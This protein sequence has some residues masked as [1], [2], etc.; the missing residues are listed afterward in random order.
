MGILKAE[1]FEVETVSN[2]VAA[3]K[4]LA[5]LRPV[6]VLADVSMPGRD[7]YEVCDFVKKSPDLSRVPVFLVAS[8]MEPYDSAKGASVKADGIIKKPFESRE[9]ISLVVKFAEQFEAATITTP[10]VPLSYLAKTESV[11]MPA[12]LIESPDSALTVIQHAAPEFSELAGGVAFAEPIGEETHPFAFEPQSV[13]SGV[14]PQSHAADFSESAFEVTSV[15]NHEYPLVADTPIQPS[16]TASGTHEE[17]EVPSFMEHLTGAP[18]EPVFINEHA[19]DAAM[20]SET[21]AAA[22][23]AIFH[24]PLDIGMPE[25][26]DKTETSSPG[27]GSADLAALEPQF[28]TEDPPISAEGGH[29]HPHDHPHDHPHLHS[30]IGATSLDSFSLDDAA[31]GQVRFASGQPE[32]VYAAPAEEAAALEAPEAAP[33]AAPARVAADG[34]TQPEVVYADPLPPEPGPEVVYAEPAAIEPA[35]IE[36]QTEASAPEILSASTALDDFSPEATLAGIH[37]GIS[38]FESADEAVAKETTPE[39]EA[40]APVAISA[41]PAPDPEK[42]EVAEP[43]NEEKHEEGHLPVAAPVA[44]LAKVIIAGRPPRGSEFVPELAIM[45]RPRKMLETAP[46]KAESPDDTIHVPEIPAEPAAEIESEAPAKVILPPPA[47]DAD[48]L[49]TIV[50]KVVMKMAPPMLTE[51][52]VEQIAKHLVHE[53]S[54][55]LSLETAKPPAA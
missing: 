47:I 34:G 20:A 35:P 36:S 52:A 44:A 17:E 53:I 5:V 14:T 54:V 4:R 10:P 30:P 39:P 43:V 38:Q 7:G 19:G 41:E 3:I 21:S 9:L 40:I 51:E 31:A 2:G 25:W 11:E 12:P 45:N 29:E 48:T 33:E 37:G 1:G 18:P 42:A 22:Q 28:I 15:P 50:L 6:V 8:D 16:T 49:Y 13:E 23:T 27:P 46:A 24:T 55:E 26:N 32:V